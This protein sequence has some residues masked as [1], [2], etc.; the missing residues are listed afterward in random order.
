MVHSLCRK[1][2]DGCDQYIMRSPFFCFRL[3]VL[4]VYGFVSTLRC[5][6]L[7]SETPRCQT[8]DCRRTSAVCKEDTLATVLRVLSW[9]AAT[10]LLGPSSLLLSV[11]AYSHY[12]IGTKDFCSCR[13][14]A[15]TARCR[16][17]FVSVLH[18]AVIQAS[19]INMTV[20]DCTAQ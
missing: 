4:E 7:R 18:V 5:R 12:S 19:A 15:L 1:F 16:T 8:E 9:H 20:G 6:K 10:T 17:S 14:E 11:V 13:P 3:V 2:N